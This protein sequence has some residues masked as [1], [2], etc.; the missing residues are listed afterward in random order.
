MVAVRRRLGSEKQ[1]QAYLELKPD[2]LVLRPVEAQTSELIDITHL[3]ELYD[4]VTV[5]DASDRVAA[6]LWLPGSKYLAGDETFI[7]YHRKSASKV[8]EIGPEKPL[9]NK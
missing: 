2:W 8:A 3:A 4:L 1:N 9:V 6:F 5:V 7:I